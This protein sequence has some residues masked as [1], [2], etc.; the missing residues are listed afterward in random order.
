[1]KSKRYLLS[2]AKTKRS[3]AA[4]LAA[5]LMAANAT[6]ASAQNKATEDNGTEGTVIG[7]VDDL[8]G[9]DPSP[10]HCTSNGT[11][12]TDR[13][14]IV[15][16][17]NVGAKKFLSV[18][19][20][21]GTH[22]SLDVSPYSIYMIWN[23]GSSTYFLKNKVIGS[24]TGLYMGI[25][26]DKDGV[27][28]VFMDR[29]EN[30]AITFELAKG[31]S[32]TNKVYLV[33]IN[34]FNPSK[35][36][37]YLTAYPDDENKF[38]DYKTSL[39]KEGSQEYENQKWKI[40]TK[41][42]Y[43]KLFNI[44][45]ANME[46]VV[47]ASFLIT[48]PDF[49]IHD[50]DAAQWIIKSEDQSADVNSHVL[51]GDKTM[52]KT[53]N[54]VSDSKDDAFIGRTEAHQQ[55]YGKYFYCYTK[56]LRGFTF[57]QDVKVHKAGWYLLRCNGF[58]T[59]VDKD[60]NVS[61]HLVMAV[62]NKDGSIDK[63]KTL[64]SVATLNKLPVDDATNLM[65][66]D[67]TGTGAGRA[68]F[69]G[70]YENQVQVCL[71]ENG[72]KAM[73][74]DKIDDDNPVTLRIGFFVDAD[75]VL[76]D[77]DVTC[78]DNFKLLY[79]G[80]RRRT[81]LILDEDQTSLLYL[82]N[83]KDSY[84]NSV[85]HLHRTLKEGQWNSL[86]LPVKLNF[87]QMKRT[88]G[89][90]VKVAKLTSL[91]DGVVIFRTVEPKIDS[92]VMVE[93]FEPY[94]IKPTSLTKELGLP[95]TAEKFYTQD[96]ENNAFWLSKDCKSESNKDDDRFSLTIPAGHYDITMV[97]LDRNELIK[98]LNLTE[99]EKTDYVDNGDW[100]DVNWNTVNWKS[101]TSF[102]TG[103]KE[104]DLTCYGTLAK[105]YNDNGILNGRD[106]LKGDYIMR[107][108]K[109]VQ[110]PSTKQYGLKGFRCWFEVKGGS[111]QAKPLRLEIDGTSDDATSIDEINS[112]PSQ[113]TSRH[114]GISGVFNLDGQK[115][116][117]G[118]STQNLPKGIY[119]VNGRKVVVM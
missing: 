40:I 109:I 23:S 53:Y 82:T 76:Q 36:L 96:D 113:F 118:K 4:A 73:G 101:S 57:Y 94:I 18:G 102:S 115:V 34:S 72:L 114:K 13:D 49:R 24:G 106:D 119:I 35:Q 43:Y 65:A 60:D 84:Q 52:Y 39:A 27:N 48:C 88:F 98:H 10:A 112:Q 81:E 17:Y 78:V 89:D 111:S 47:D 46:S 25:F 44:T 41:K 67:A 105:T 37:G 108:G 54:K 51:F 97:T 68:F 16:L 15:C 14:K 56:G 9:V 42:E 64:Y 77:G 7:G 33:K 99:K 5:V 2:F 3:I 70:N 21:W 69:D 92:D 66:A 55:N 29:K 85:L 59:Q 86:I 30:C 75:C 8:W 90:D 91:K 19:G 32:E 74:I 62:L 28:G 50:T 1:M 100:V 79:A 31:Y 45:P 38:C 93:A 116:R 80:E 61:A 87:G 103:A 83:A 63:T 11:D 58:T 104:G 22:A 71:D 117:E 6:V 95:Y 107:D 26:K 20:K 110:V 12:E